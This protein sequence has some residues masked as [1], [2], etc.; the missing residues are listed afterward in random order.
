MSIATIVFMRFRPRR[1]S[2]PEPAGR[3][4]GKS[5]DTG[6]WLRWL[7]LCVMTKSILW[8]LLA[9]P[10]LLLTG[11]ATSVLWEDGCFARFHEPAAAPDLCLFQGGRDVLVQ[12]TETRDS[13]EKQW[14]RTYWLH[15]NEQRINERRK[16][17]FVP[18]QTAKGLVSIPVLAPFGDTTRMLGC[19]VYALNST[20][21][22][23]FT[24]YEAGGQKLSECQLPVYCDASGRVKQVLLTPV[25]VVA[26]CTIVGGCIAYELLPGAWPGLN[27]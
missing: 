2:Q 26:D 25:C 8:P 5:I 23:S 15:Q 9:F 10:L 11:C 24:L 3:L 18:E 20:N 1:F 16:P 12:Y 7:T 21:R 14:R 22:G 4:E 19:K 17:R 27:H 6:G 13:D